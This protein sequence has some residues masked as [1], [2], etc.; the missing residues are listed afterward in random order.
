M[1][2]DA[3][4]DPDEVQELADFAELDAAIRLTPLPISSLQIDGM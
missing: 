3:D 2:D 1:P 4:N